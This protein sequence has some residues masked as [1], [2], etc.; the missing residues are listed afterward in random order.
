MRKTAFAAVVSLSLCTCLIPAVYAGVTNPDISVIGQIISQKNDNAAS[1][2]ANTAT[3]HLGET[4]LVCDAWLNP[5][6]RGFF[7]FAIGTDGLATEEA[8]IAIIKGLPGTLNLKGG[9]YR[10]G[11]GKLNPVHPHAYPFIEAPRVL[12]AMLPGGEDGFNDV[13]AQ[14]SVLLPSAGSWPPTFRLMC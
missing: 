3:L 1:E 2:N 10:V 6:A 9:Q 11:F 5:Y 7:V 8:Y 13:G 4:E 12:S 14:A